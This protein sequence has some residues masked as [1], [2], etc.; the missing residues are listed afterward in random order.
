MACRRASDPCLR[1]PSHSA[2][3]CSPDAPGTAEE[4]QPVLEN[5]A[6]F[7]AMD[8]GDL[9]SFA[10][11]H[12]SYEL[13]MLGETAGWLVTAPP[14]APLPTWNAYIESFGIHARALGDFLANRGNH[15][16][17]VLAK[18]YAPHWTAEDPA[19]GLAKIVDKQVA[20]LTSVRL[21]KAPINPGEALT[22]L[23][24][25][26]EHF[27]LAVPEPRRLWFDWF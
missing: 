19:S 23:N 21:E 4:S 2:A 6:S 22:Q 25:S 5:Q 3:G 12:L 1:T 8:D 17:D 7:L 16:D 9:E 11:E 24:E 26:F 15:R 18:H 20:H 27:V 10:R 14:G 13:W